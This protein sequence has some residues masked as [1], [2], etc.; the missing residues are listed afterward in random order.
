[1]IRAYRMYKN[2]LIPFKVEF[3]WFPEHFR[4]VGCGRFFRLTTFIAGFHVVNSYCSTCNVT[5]M[6]MV[7]LKTSYNLTETRK[8]GN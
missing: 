6:H 4:N 7:T 2:L 8:R 3:L 5:A 1:M